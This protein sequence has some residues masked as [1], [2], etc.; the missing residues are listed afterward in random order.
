M[1]R[2]LFLPVA[3]CLLFALNVAAQQQSPSKILKQAE[4]A[5]GGAKALQNLRNVRKKG[6][7]TR[8]KDGATGVFLMQTTQ[9]NFYNESYDLGGFETESGYNGKSGWARDSRDGLRTLTGKASVDFQAEVN[10][11]NNLWLNYKREKSKILSA[12][13]RKSTTKPP[14][15]ASI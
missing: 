5:L 6:T 1:K 7:I 4:K 3:A 11:R 10:Y 9:P 2:I 15:I 12:V 14:P 13:R 8:I